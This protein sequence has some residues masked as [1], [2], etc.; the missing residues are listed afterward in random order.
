M[1][2]LHVPVAPSTHH[3]GDFKSPLFAQGIPSAKASF[4]HDLK[5]NDPVL[6][7]GSHGLKSATS[8]SNIRLKPISAILRF[9][10]WLIYR[11]PHRPRSSA[12]HSEPLRLTGSK[13]S[14]CIEELFIRAHSWI[15]SRRLRRG[16][17]PIRRAAIRLGSEDHHERGAIRPRS[18]HKQMPKR[19]QF[20]RHSVSFSGF[21][22]ATPTSATPFPPNG[23][24]NLNQNEN[25]IDHPGP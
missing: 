16:R 18:I 13:A 9:G 3:L 19:N 23:R 24:T 25:T 20:D 1:I 21:T 2:P 4:A 11:C 14:G 15:L 8:G 22:P 6:R 10:L 5:I 7:I 12:R 17:A